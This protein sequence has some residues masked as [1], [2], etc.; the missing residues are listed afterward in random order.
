MLWWLL[1]GIPCALAVPVCVARAWQAWG[2]RRAEQ[3]DEALSR[4]VSD[5]LNV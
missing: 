5:N 3:V 1:I 4:E 2:I